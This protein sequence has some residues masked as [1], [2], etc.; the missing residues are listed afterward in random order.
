MDGKR[1]QTF[2][3]IYR[4]F[5]AVTVSAS[6]IALAVLCIKIYST[7]DRAFTREIIADN[8]ALLA[9][10]FYI[11]ALVVIAGL[12][13][14][15]DNRKR[16]AKPDAMTLLAFYKKCYALNVDNARKEEKTRVILKSVFGAICGIIAIFP[17]CYLMN[18]S[19]FS[20][21]DI[22]ADII[23]AAFAVFIPAA[24]VFL[25]SLICVFL[26]N[27]SVKREI[28][29]YKSA[30]ADGTA[31]RINGLRTSKN[32]GVLYV[33]CILLTVS[34]ALIVLGVFNDG[35]GDVYGKAIRIC[36]ECIGLG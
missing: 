26:C 7:G 24:I 13:F 6:F 16:Q 28:E 30:I 33:R 18:K 9:P 8:V 2:F 11:T 19:N 29:I 25:I 21:E 27:R 5:T 31:E 36:T 10:L 3:G 12:I 23:S 17:V 34:V 4:W 22:N 14:I 32:N 1:K 35:I 20:V 15:S